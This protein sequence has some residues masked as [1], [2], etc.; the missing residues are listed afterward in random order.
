MSERL[1]HNEEMEMWKS[2]MQTREY[3]KKMEDSLSRELEIQAVVG[4]SGF[5]AGRVGKEK[6]WWA[7]V[8][9]TAWRE[10]EGEIQ[11]EGILL[12]TVADDKLLEHLQNTVKEDSVIRCSVRPSK[13]GSY[14]LMTGPVQ[15]GDDPELKKILE[16]Q[17]QEITMDVEGLG[18]FVLERSVDWF[19]ARADWLGTEIN[20]SFDQDEEEVMESAIETARRLMGDQAGWDQRI[21]EFAADELLGLAND[22]AENAAEEEELE[23]MEDGQLVSR[24]QFMERME[25]ESIQAQEEGEFEFWFWDGDMFYGHSIHVTGNLEDGPDWAGIEG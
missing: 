1:D 25:L 17:M 18:T 8:E 15:E 5:G 24:K 19:E 20:L 14:L 10:E 22:W 12:S 21:R 7:S 9:L 11:Q 3:R 13:N 4:A 16:E 2:I 23:S 6:F